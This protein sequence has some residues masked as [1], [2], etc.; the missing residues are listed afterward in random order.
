MIRKTALI[1][2][3]IGLFAIAGCGSADEPETAENHEE[4]STPHWEYQGENGPEQWGNLHEAFNLCGTGQKQSPINVT[5]AMG[6]DLNNLVFDY[7]ATTLELVHNGHTVQVNHASDST[8]TIDNMAYELVQFHFHAPS[9][10]TIDGKSFPVEMHL[11]HANEAGELAVVGVM[12]EEGAENPA[13][14]S[15][16]EYLPSQAGPLEAIEEVYVDAAHLL[17]SNPATFRYDGSLTTPPCSENVKW[18]LFTTPITMTADQIVTF[19]NAVKF[20]NNRPVQ[21]LNDRVVEE[22]VSAN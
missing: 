18:N 16:W 15:V 1:F 7:K 6:T 10:H 11:V 2:I 17:P 5:G 12:I 20:A 21:P 9:E 22:D 19:E 13:L 14:S 8:V 4:S 3:I